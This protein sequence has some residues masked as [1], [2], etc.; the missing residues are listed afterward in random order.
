[1]TETFDFADCLEPL[2]SL[3]GDHYQYNNQIKQRMNK[4]IL[5]TVV[6]PTFRIS[7]Y[8]NVRQKEKRKSKVFYEPN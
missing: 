2:L 7:L 1:M 6:E 5:S 4:E 8:V 3:N